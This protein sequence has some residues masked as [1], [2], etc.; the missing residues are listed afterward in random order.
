MVEFNSEL[1]KGQPK[2]DKDYWKSQQ[3]EKGDETPVFESNIKA[4]FTS[5]D[6]ISIFKK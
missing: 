2:L 5:L 6:K 4:T 1:P 3:A